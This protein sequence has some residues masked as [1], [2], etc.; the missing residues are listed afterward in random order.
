M[1]PLEKAR[2]ALDGAVEAVEDALTDLQAIAPRA[3][4]GKSFIL[5]DKL[6][7]DLNRAARLARRAIRLVDSHSQSEPKEDNGT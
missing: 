3:L 7:D 1:T 4:A 5:S 2:E 6:F